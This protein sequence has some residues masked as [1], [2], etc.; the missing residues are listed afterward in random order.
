MIPPIHSLPT[1]RLPFILLLVGSLWL[2]EI[3]RAT[4]PDSSAEPVALEPAAVIFRTKCAACH[5]ADGQGVADAYKKPLRGDHSLDE[6]AQ[7]IEETMPEEN[8]DECVGEEAR[9]LAE[10]VRREF[11]SRAG[12]LSA[13]RFALA[14]LTVDQY[15]NSIADTIGRLA[16]VQ[17]SPTDD[18][19]FASRRRSPTDSVPGLRGEYY[20]SRGMSKADS[21]GQ[22][23]SDTRIDF[24]FGDGSPVPTISA[25]QFTI[26]WEG[27]L[28]AD[29]TGHYEFRVS[30]QNGARLYLNLDSQASRRRLRDDSSAAGQTALIDAWVGSGEMRERSARVFLL[31]GR[32]YPIRLEFFKYLEETASIKL[33]WKAPHGTWAVLDY[34]DTTTVRP[35]RVFVCE[36]PFPADDR[37]LG[38][39]RGS[40]I[41]SQWQEAT[42]NAA[43]AAAAEIVQRLPL[44]AE[45]GEG[46]A[47]RSKQV[48]EFLLRFA[49]IA[50]RRPLTNS[51]QEWLVELAETDSATVESV[52]R[53]A[54]V[55]VLMSPHF[56]YTDLTPVGE[57]PTPYATAAR[58]SYALWDSI[59]DQEL[60]EAAAKGKL[61]TTEQIAE[62]ARRMVAHPRTRAKMRSFF[63]NWL[64]LEDRDLSKD[65][66]MF[67][68]FDEDVI[69]DLRRSLDLFIERIIWSRESDYRQLLQA[70]YLVLNDR[71]RRL[72]APEKAEKQERLDGETIKERARRLHF[73]SSFQQVPLTASQRS[74]V[75]THPYLLSAYAYHDNTSPIHRGVFLTR[76]IVGRVLSP[77]P[78]AVAFK[79]DD[80]A[81]DLTMR[82]KITQLTRDTACMSCH[83]V[84]NPLGFSLENFDAVGR[85]RTTDNNKPVDTKSDFTTSSGETV[86]IAGA[87]DVADFAV[88]SEVAHRA[89]VTHVFQ[90]VVKQ[91]PAFY[92]DGLIEE[93]RSHFAD[94]EFN[95]QK[96][97]A[98]IATVAAAHGLE[99]N[100]KSN[101]QGT[102]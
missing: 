74:G 65:K 92:G 31:G 62:Q 28:F 29:H 89:F 11:Y 18:W 83:S 33:E 98:R 70:D 101:S 5:G 26:I 96:L 12:D 75:L 47:E 30:T 32:T 84:I 94:D 73:A 22:Y 14:R 68:N 34:N 25:D 86:Q 90:H 2:P 20:Q 66:Q 52:V 71:L 57:V 55:A 51:E 69:A 48:Q 37:S 40:S 49:S 72:Y 16:P 23:R 38:Y 44:L 35:P 63:H 1:L 78:I 6:L 39:E 46:S 17:A 76:N 97:W 10:F 79:S 3:G 56:L 67:P 99:T 13:P 27:G 81:S 54:V 21:L 100:S 15:R 7:I 85:W 50:Y 42:T 41:S 45:L 24:D 19:R 82:E 9:L 93:L 102:P 87:R 64:E 43:V 4:E 91:D 8:P 77:P 58:L 59:P 61:Q 95:V 36:A 80:F 53:G 60:L 88:S